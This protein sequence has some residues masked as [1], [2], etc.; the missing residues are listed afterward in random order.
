MKSICKTAVLAQL[1]A[2]SLCVGACSPQEDAHLTCAT[3]I[4]V[5]DKLM[6]TGKVPNDLAL[7]Q[8]ANDAE[9]NHQNASATFRRL[10][11]RE[12]EGEHERLMELAFI[13]GKER[14]RIL[15]ELSPKEVVARAKTCIEQA[16]PKGRG[17]PRPDGSF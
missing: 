1:V 16:P 7:R 4:F 14:D 15:N 12:P 10:D 9:V 3:T 6:E 5:A 11:T 13:F 17:F 8:K 2:A